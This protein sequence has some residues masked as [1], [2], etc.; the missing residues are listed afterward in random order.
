MNAVASKPEP[1]PQK[2]S[3]EKSPIPILSMIG[4]LLSIGIYF[5]NISVYAVSV[6]MIPLVMLSAFLTN[7]YGI[8][9]AVPSVGALALLGGYTALNYLNRDSIDTMPG[10]WKAYNTIIGALVSAHFVFLMIGKGFKQLTW[11]TFSGLLLFVLMQYVIS[12][13]FRTNG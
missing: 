13:H 1:P 10:N 3:T 8:Y 11:V 2:T 9:M 4:A 5:P 7:Y 12:T 6:C